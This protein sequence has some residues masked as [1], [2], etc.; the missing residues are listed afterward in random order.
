MRK[1]GQVAS[2]VGHGRSVEEVRRSIDFTLHPPTAALTFS[3]DAMAYTSVL[4]IVWCPSAAW[5]TRRSAVR[6]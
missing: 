6:S 1:V 5:T 3:A 4:E 2:K